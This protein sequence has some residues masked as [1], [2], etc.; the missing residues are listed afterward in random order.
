MIEHFLY[1]MILLL[2]P[3]NN[4][5]LTSMSPILQMGKQRHQVLKCQAPTAGK[6][7]DQ[8]GAWHLGLTLH[9]GLGEGKQELLL[10]CDRGSK[11]LCSV[12]EEAHWAE[13]RL[14]GIGQATSLSGLVQIK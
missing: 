6:W 9:C 10:Q 4:Q 13:S 12:T 7:R 3:R 5:I 14:C 11:R 1:A 8:V 2:S